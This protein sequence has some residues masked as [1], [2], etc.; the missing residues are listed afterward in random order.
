[1]MPGSTG[2][3]KLLKK[4]QARRIDRVTLMA[5]HYNGQVL[6]GSEDGRKTS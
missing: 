3:P 6:S 1:M 5:V 2:E 4:S